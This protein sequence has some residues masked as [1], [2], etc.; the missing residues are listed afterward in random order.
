MELTSLLSFV[1]SGRK[2]WVCRRP[3]YGSRHIGFRLHGQREKEYGVLI[4]IGHGP[5]QEFEIFVPF[6]RMFVQGAN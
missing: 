2:D 4:L 3:Q 6:L 1:I 5:T